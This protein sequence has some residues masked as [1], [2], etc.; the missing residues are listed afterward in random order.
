[1]ARVLEYKCPCCG[2]AIQFDSGLQKMRCPYCDTEFELETLQQFEQEE[3]KKEDLPDWEEV[4]GEH[5]TMEDTDGTFVSYV[6]EACGGEIIADR[7]MASSHCPYCDNPVI[8][9]QQLS[10]GLKPDLIIPFQ[11]DKK[12]AVEGFKKH[13]KGKTLLPRAFRTDSKIEEIKGVYV[14]FWLFS[15]KAEADIRCR[16]T[17][18]RV[19]RSGKYE[20]TE[21]SHYLVSR[22][23]DL[24]F[25]QVPVDGSQKMADDLMDSVEPYDYSGAQDFKMAYLAGYLADKYDVTS[26]ECAP[27]ANTRISASTE[28][29]F[30]DTI[31]GYATCIP[32]KK[33]ITMETGSIRYALLP[34]W[35]LH[36]TYKGKLFT[37][38]MNGQTG[39]FVGNLP[40]DAP[41]AA[42][43]SGSIFAGVSV[44]LFAILTLLFC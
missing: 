35:L 40:L 44:L 27:R 2:G 6:C 24:A 42:L 28:R 3:L 13:L 7:S 19:W 43:L 1:M 32:E 41:K 33:D 16:A 4:S 20:Y 37:F 9:M 15:C 31:N 8:V 34:V 29:Q 5:E 11:L 22:A 26:E 36:T 30:M 23:G 14:P 18:V 39:K 12:T 21:T 25:E 38:A 17:R 10:G